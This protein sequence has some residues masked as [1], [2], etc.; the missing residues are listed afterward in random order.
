MVNFDNI[1]KDFNFIKVDPKYTDVNF[2]FEKGSS[3]SLDMTHKNVSFDYPNS[4]AEIQQNINPN[5]NK[6]FITYGTIGTNKTKLSKLKIEA[7]SCNISIRVM[8][9]RRGIAPCLR[10]SKS[11]H[12]LRL[13]IGSSWRR[14]RNR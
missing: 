12:S 4:I 7:E 9:I 10:F 3:Y 6:G 2:M 5:D 8:G 13:E 14:L 11:R 1:S